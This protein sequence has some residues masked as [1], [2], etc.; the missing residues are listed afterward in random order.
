MPEARL[1]RCRRAYA[2]PER[3]VRVTAD[4]VTTAAIATERK[5][6]KRLAYHAQELSPIWRML[7]K[8]RVKQDG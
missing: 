7:T 2:E 6:R 3:T 4:D 8:G 1:E 5:L